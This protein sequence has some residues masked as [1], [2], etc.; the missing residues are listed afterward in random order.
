[1][2][3][4]DEWNQ[5]LPPPKGAP[6]ALASAIVKALREGIEDVYSGEMAQEWLERWRKNPKVLESELAVGG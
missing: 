3:D 2:D 5:S 6:A 4:D 1:M